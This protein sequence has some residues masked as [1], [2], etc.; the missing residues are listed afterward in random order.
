MLGL[1]PVFKKEKEGLNV[2]HSKDVTHHGIDVAEE[3]STLMSG[4]QAVDFEKSAQRGRAGKRHPFQVDDQVGVPLTSQMFL[5]VA[6]QGLDGQGVQTQA[7]PEF[8]KQCAV[9]AMQLDRRT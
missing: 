4:R 2:A 9:R 6:V 1:L 7:I 5:E 3:Q 8:R